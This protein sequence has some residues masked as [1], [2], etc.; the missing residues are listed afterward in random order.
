MNIFFHDLLLDINQVIFAV[1]I[2]LLG[3]INSGFWGFF[4]ET[5]SYF[6]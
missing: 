3:G 5:L 1:S 2:H 4:E 6:T